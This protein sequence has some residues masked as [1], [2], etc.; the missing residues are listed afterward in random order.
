M[1]FQICI[2]FQVEEAFNGKRMIPPHAATFYGKPTL[3][4]VI[5]EAKKDEFEVHSHTHERIGMAKRRISE[6]V[7]QPVGDLT[8]ECRDT[9]IGKFF[10][11]VAKTL[12]NS[13]T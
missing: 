8:F 9:T 5:Y 1:N 11:Y 2:I 4:K 3:I 13:S 6:K 12:A 10:T 7:Q